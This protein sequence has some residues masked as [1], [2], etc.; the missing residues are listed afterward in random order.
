MSSMFDF[1]FCINAK[2]FLEEGRQASV[3]RQPLLDTW[4]D[5]HICNAERI[6]ILLE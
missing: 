6:G 2:L 3:G 1:S 5:C 4:E